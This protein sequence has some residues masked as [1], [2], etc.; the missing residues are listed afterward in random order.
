MYTLGYS[1]RPWRQPK[2]IADGPSILQYIR[3]TAEAYGIDREI[4]YG[5]RVES[6]RWSSPDARWTVEARDAS[7][8]IV[9]LT[10]SFLFML[11]RLLRLRRRLHAGLPRP[12]TVPRAHRAPAEVDP[13]R[14]L[15]GQAR[16]R[17]RQ[18]RDGGDARARAGQAGRARDDAPALADVHRLAARARRDRH[19]AAQASAGRVRL[20]GHALEERPQ[21]HGLLHVLQAFPGARQ[22]LPRGPGEKGPRRKGRRRE[23]LHAFL[24]SVGP[25]PLPRA[26]RR[27]RST[28]SARGALRSSRITSTRSP[29]RASGCG[30]ARSSR[31]T[32]S[33]PRRGSG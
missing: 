33:S 11:R 24:R 20:R 14:R 12:R 18:R 9:R 28:R 23:A 2:A 31:R 26:G 22:A 10:C 3:E 27:S 16:R 32:S 8:E 15:R 17:H 13:R 7:G 30:P 6:A 5:H 25:A 4:R 29:R 21:R 1:F 19:L